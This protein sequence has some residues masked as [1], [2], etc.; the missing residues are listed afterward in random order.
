[1]PLV[2]G[3]LA[4]LTFDLWATSVLIKQGHRIRV[5]IAGADA[6]TFLRYPRDGGEP[7]ITVSRSSLYPSSIVL[8]MKER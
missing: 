3:E 7:T 8:P 2:P 4:E 1:M 5:A 6:D